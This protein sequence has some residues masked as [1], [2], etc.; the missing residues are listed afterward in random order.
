MRMTPAKLRE[1]AA[2]L[3]EKAASTSRLASHAADHAPGAYVTGGS[4]R[5]RAQN[6]ATARAI[7][8]TVRLAC[9]SRDAAQEASHLE[10]KAA[11][12]EDA[13]NRARVREGVAAKECA[14]RARVAA[15]PMINDPSAPW[16]MTSAEWRTLHKDFKTIVECDGVRVR[17]AVQP[18]ARGGGLAKVFLTDRPK[19]AA[20]I[21]HNQSA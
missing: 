6:R 17:S 12:I 15:L 2:R 13:P 9:A 5:T 19:I 8:R 1:K 16:H 4:G 14:E 10:A 3:R 11:W 18:A 20:R 7:E 21:S